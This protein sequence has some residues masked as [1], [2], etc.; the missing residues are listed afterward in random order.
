MTS[1]CASIGRC[2]FLFFFLS[3]VTFL[4]SLS[5][6]HYQ[7]SCHIVIAVEDPAA[8][9]AEELI[10]GIAAAIAVTAAAEIPSKE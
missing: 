1:Y 2:S 3:F 5:Y 7:S 9:E 4:C 8:E 6:V 10:A